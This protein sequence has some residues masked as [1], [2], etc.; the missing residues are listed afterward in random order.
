M[1]KKNMSYARAVSGALIVSD[2][3]GFQFTYRLRCPHCNFVDPQVSIAVA[4]INEPF[5]DHDV[6][7][8]CGKPFEIIVER[9]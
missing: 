4:D 2:D 5:I 7:A 1:E 3:N 8:K 9:V 6:C